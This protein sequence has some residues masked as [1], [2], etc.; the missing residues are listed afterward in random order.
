[1]CYVGLL[2]VFQFCNVV[3]LWMLLTGSGD[4][5]CGMLSALFQAVAYHL[6]F[7]SPSA[8][9]AFVYWK[10]TQRSAPCLSPLLWC[11]QSTL[12]PLQHIPFQFFIYHSVF[13]FRAGGQSVQGAILV[14]PRGGCVFAHLLVC[15]VSPKQIWSQC[16][17]A[18][19]PSYFLSV[20]WHRESLHDLG[21]QGVE[22]LIHLGVFFFFCQ[23]WLQHL[24]K[25]FV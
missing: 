15:W 7:V 22:L 9:P 20:T 13:F 4:E 12:L 24:S 17:V 6:P 11:A 21:V 14:Y 5:F 1:V 2:I 23:V 16:L 3:W 10:F 25:I 19:E 18:Q 8:F